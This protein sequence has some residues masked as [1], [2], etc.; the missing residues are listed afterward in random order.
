[1]GALE[2]ALARA[3]EQSGE[4]IVIGQ[5]AARRPQPAAVVEDVDAALME[6]VAARAIP[7]TKGDAPTAEAVAAIRAAV[8]QD[9]K[10]VATQALAGLRFFCDQNGELRMDLYAKNGRRDVPAAGSEAAKDYVRSR[11]QQATGRP[12]SEAAV[13]S[14]LVEFRANARSSGEQENVYVR[15]APYGADGYAH[16][17]A[18]AEGRAVVIWAERDGNGWE[19]RQGVEVAF[20]RGAGSGSLPI[21]ERPASLEGAYQVITEALRSWGV[22]DDDAPRVVAGALICMRH[23]VPKPIFEFTGAP[24]ARKTTTACHLINTLD[25]AMTST[26]PTVK[27]TEGDIAAS[28]QSRAMLFHDNASGLSGDASD[29]MARSATGTVLSARKLYTQGDTFTAAV[30]VAFVVTAL[31]P[32]I[33]RGDARSRVVPISLQPPRHYA[34]EDDVRREF[35]E[36]RPR[37]LGALYTLLSAALA[38]LDEVKGQRAYKHRMVDYEQTGEAMFQALGRPVGWF[39]EV[40]EKLRQGEAATAAQEDPI[41]SGL[42]SEMQRILDSAENRPK[43]NPANRWVKSTGWDAWKQPTK[44]GASV[45]TGAASMGHLL[46]SLSQGRFVSGYANGWLPANELQLQRATQHL[47]PTLAAIGWHIHTKTLG[48]R[49]C[50]VFS[51]V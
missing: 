23:G 34:S 22:K 4:A 36:Q 18:D 5:K 25:P 42:V 13:D 39:G 40:L 47:I 9:A 33:T 44:G 38:R 20:L 29:L 45:A 12:C 26:A 35:A 31:A 14:L 3:R 15:I 11:V 16:D 10:Q 48:N 6:A 8:Q 37:I 19:V 32:V 41:A 50:L 17:L 30:Q 2:K 24:G 51:R 1:M 46:R 7:A 49:S 43:P 27:T 28:A 21:P